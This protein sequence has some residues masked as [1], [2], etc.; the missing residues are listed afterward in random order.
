[1]IQSATVIVQ[2]M[3]N[4]FISTEMLSLLPSFQYDS[5]FIWRCAKRVKISNTV[6]QYD[7]LLYKTGFGADEVYGQKDRHD[8]VILRHGD[9]ERTVLIEGGLELND[10]DLP[11]HS[12]LVLFRLIEPTEA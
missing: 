8:A 1:M 11:S 12:R 3:S 2:S 7:E 6:P 9:I 5:E 10:R 4:S